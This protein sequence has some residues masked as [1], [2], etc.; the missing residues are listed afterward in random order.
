GM[1]CLD[2]LVG[3]VQDDVEEF[4]QERAHRYIFVGHQFF[5]SRGC[6]IGVSTNTSPL[7]WSASSAR[8]KV[9][10]SVISASTSSSGGAKTVSASSATRPVGMSNV[11]PRR[12]AMLLGLRS[13][14][15]IRLPR[16]RYSRR[17]H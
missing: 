11:A 17:C 10:H 7:S 3:G 16:R 9:I 1:H 13:A 8:A 12:P 2:T 4:D 15:S 14:A 6:A 5:P